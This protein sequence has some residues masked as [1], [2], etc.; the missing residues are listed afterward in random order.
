MIIIA[1]SN[2]FLKYA[3]KVNGQEE[4]DDVKLWKGEQKRHSKR[5]GWHLKTRLKGSARGLPVTGAETQDLVPRL[6]SAKVRP[7]PDLLTKLWA[8]PALSTVVGRG[9]RARRTEAPAAVSVLVTFMLQPWGVKAI[10]GP[11][12]CPSRRAR[13]LHG[14]PVPSAL[15]FKSKF[16]W[17]WYWIH[18]DV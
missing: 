8:K 5:G 7:A 14:D 10:W 4:E 6:R 3:W 13:C 12:H 9:D 18:C 2:T 1:L 11:K 17:R 16:A 15:I